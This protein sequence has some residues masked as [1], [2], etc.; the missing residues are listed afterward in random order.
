MYN[1]QNEHG[2]LLIALFSPVFGVIFK[3]ILRLC[4][5]RLKKI[6]HPGYSYI[7]LVPLYFGSAIMFRVMQA[8][9]ENLKLI[10]VLG[11]IHGAVE[12][13]E[14]STPRRERL[15]ADITILGMLCESTAIVSVNGLLYLYQFIYS[16]NI[17]LLKL[18]QEFAIH[19]S[20]PLVIEWFFTGVSLAIETR[21]QNIAVMTIWR[22]RWK[23]HILV[24][25]TNLVPLAI[26]TTA[27]LWEVVRGRFDKS[28]DHPCKMPF[29]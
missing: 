17:S 22:K 19:T 29:T 15:M 5:Q 13:L 21:F 4:T 9:L 10:A 1:K 23:R 18:L 2:K 27:N 28:K 14:R 26:W 11:I 24:A 3:V 8:E 16:Q 20:V 7:L 25:I 6:A 12:V